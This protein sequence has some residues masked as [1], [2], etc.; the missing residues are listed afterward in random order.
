MACTSITRGGSALISYLDSD[1]Y[2]LSHA[3]KQGRQDRA[4]R[5]EAVGADESECY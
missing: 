2:F 5:T 4:G 1:E 3:H